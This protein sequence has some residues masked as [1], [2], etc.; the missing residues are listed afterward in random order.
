MYTTRA[1]KG[2]EV[3]LHTL[4]SALAEVCGQLYP[5]EKSPH[6]WLNR[7]HVP[8]SQSV[9]S[10]EEKNLV[11][12]LGIQFL[13][14]PAHSWITILS[15]LSPLPMKLNI[16]FAAFYLLISTCCFITYQSL[17]LFFFL[18]YS[19]GLFCIKFDNCSNYTGKNLKNK[20]YQCS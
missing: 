10:E 1:Y 7:L 18:K 11:P 13:N 6:Y 14:C 16:F 3:H 12:L 2:E 4:T 9:Y 19:W 5:W 17:F 15:T 20:L 8:Q